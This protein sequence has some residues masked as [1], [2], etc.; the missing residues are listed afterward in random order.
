MIVMERF[1][2]SSLVK[3]YDQSKIS[4]LRVRIVGCGA[5]GTH[6]AL[7]VAGFGVELIALYD[8]DKVEESNLSR[9]HFENDDV[10]KVKSVALQSI[11]QKRIVETITRVSAYEDRITVDNIDDLIR[12]DETDIV[13]FCVDSINDRLMMNDY[14]VKANIPFI[15]G[16]TSKG[17]YGEICTV[18]PG[19]TACLRC[20]MKPDPVREACA[21]DEKEPSIIGNSMVI[22]SMMVE[23]FQ[24]WA[25]GMATTP[26]VLKFA[27]GRMMPVNDLDETSE[28]HPQP[29]YYIKK[30]PAPNCVCRKR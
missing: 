12:A 8:P 26:P 25:L 14:L 22:A 16:G 13:L 7:G 9:Q 17:I 10:G 21:A 3:G 23:E 2:R 30:L 28:K 6:V 1:S 20:F 18:I 4:K 27:S 5:L 19:K 11:L 29:F 24:K 15:N